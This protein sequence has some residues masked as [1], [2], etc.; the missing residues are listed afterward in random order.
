MRHP[1]TNGICERFHKTILNKFY[2]VVFRKK[3]YLSID[4]L[5][6]DLDEWLH[7][8]N[9]NRTHQGKMCCGRAPIQ[10]PV[11]GKEAWHDKIT[12]LNG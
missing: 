9:Y 4:A 5:Q 8:Y 2:H 10:T 3:I 12:K 6:K 11:D 1:Q 7:N